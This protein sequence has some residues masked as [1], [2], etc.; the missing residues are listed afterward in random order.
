MCSIVLVE[1]DTKW[2]TE[3]DKAPD[4]FKKIKGLKAMVAHP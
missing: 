3:K 4:F 1:W 2:D